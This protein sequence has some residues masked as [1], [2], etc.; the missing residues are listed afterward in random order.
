M[1]NL[2]LQSDVLLSNDA[3]QLQSPSVDDLD[4]IAHFALERCISNPLVRELSNLS[5]ASDQGGAH[6][7]PFGRGHEEIAGKKDID[8]SASSPIC[9]LSPKYRIPQMPQIRNSDP[10]E[11]KVPLQSINPI[12]T[13]TMTNMPPGLQ[14]QRMTR[15]QFGENV[16]TNSDRFKRPQQPPPKQPMYD[17]STLSIPDIIK[18]NLSLKQLLKHSMVLKLIKHG[19][20][21]RFIQDK[22]KIAPHEVRDRVLY[23]I[24]E[25]DNL[26]SCSK[27]I[28]GNYVMQIFFEHGNKVQ[29][30]LLCSHLLKSNMMELS[31]S[32]YGCRVVQK[33]MECVDKSELI[34][35]VAELDKPQLINA[36]IVGHNA[37]HVVQKVLGLGLG[38]EHIRF[39]IDEIDK[40]IC[41]YAKHI[42]GCRIVQ[43]IICH[44]G[45][46][47]DKALIRMHFMKKAKDENVLE[48]CTS[49]YGNY[50]IQ[51]ILQLQY[52]NDDCQQIKNYFIK[53][54]FKH[55][56]VLSKNKFGSNV[57]EKCIMNS[58]SKQIDFLLRQVAT[59]K[60]IKFLGKMMND[61]FA[62]YCVQ[63]L[64]VSCNAK[65][66]KRL[67][68]AIEAN[69]EAVRG[70]NT[71]Y[72]KH[73]MEKV[74]QIKHRLQSQESD[75][76]P[77]R[78]RR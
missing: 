72:G 47:D 51:D 39:I 29:H 4:I 69:I 22:L 7:V 21:S 41:F 62:N 33:A 44:Y 8:F 58:S 46:V 55:V 31:R 77:S 60:N 17:I 9:I 34:P 14:P 32:P 40:D 20:G 2:H 3:F 42:F 30:Q 74:E 68:V 11:Y 66:Q 73:I 56:W 54:I 28:Y 10:T 70:A 59:G 71:H 18:Q 67:V 5:V 15:F 35:L 1:N 65:Q 6:F 57:V 38:Y 50:V 53:K 36:L 45:H 64:L 24:I 63:K 16:I 19:A 25:V 52:G 26:F 27:D 12:N 49:K 37:N 61:K 23:H 75:K 76:Q 13:N 48:L 43:S 78:W